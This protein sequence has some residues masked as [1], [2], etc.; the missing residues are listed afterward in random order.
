MSGVLI[1]FLLP[2]YPGAFLVFHDLISECLGAREKTGRGWV[3]CSCWDG[4]LRWWLRI[5]LGG[6]SGTSDACGRSPW[7]LVPGVRLPRSRP[8]RRW[9]A[10]PAASLPPITPTGFP[11]VPGQRPRLGPTKATPAAVTHRPYSNATD[12]TPDIRRTQSS[13][14]PELERNPE[15]RPAN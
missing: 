3:I 14:S 12:E 1:P 8:A 9:R 13:E 11:A 6:W 2:V 15:T 5:S 7:Q 10:S 4:R